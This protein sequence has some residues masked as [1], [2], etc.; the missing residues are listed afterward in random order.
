MVVGTLAQ[1]L[2]SS[3]RRAD[4]HSYAPVASWSVVV[5]EPELYLL[6]SSRIVRRA[7]CVATDRAG[8]GT[9]TGHSSF[10]PE[11]FVRYLIG[12]IPTLRTILPPY[13]YVGNI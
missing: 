9:R 4:R 7:S 6:T 5:A 3:E 11:D 8:G 13:T 12:T 2:R 1:R 10:H